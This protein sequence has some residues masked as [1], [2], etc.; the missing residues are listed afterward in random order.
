MNA[1]LR[2]LKLRLVHSLQLQ[3]L[4]L[5]PKLQSRQFSNRRLFQPRLSLLNRLKT[6][7]SNSL[8][9]H[10]FNPVLL[11]WLYN[12]PKM[13]SS[14]LFSTTSNQCQAIT[15]QLLPICPP[16]PTQTSDNF[17]KIYKIA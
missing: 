6:H 17:L 3:F 7:N 16:S 12:H 15:N 8:K 10:L 4:R 2:Q 1:P 13:K 14:L 11:K 9:L 5:K